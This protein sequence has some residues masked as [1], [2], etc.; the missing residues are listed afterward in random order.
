MEILKE[1]AKAP[2][3]KGKNQDG[4]TISLEDYSGKMVIL[5]FYPKDNTPGCTTEACN[6]RDNYDELVSRGFV[7]I[8]VSPDTEKSHIK[9]RGKHQLPFHLIAD[10]DKDIIKAYGAWGEK[11]LYGR[12]YEGVLRTTY[13]IDEKG[14]ILKIINKVNTSNHAG[15]IMESLGIT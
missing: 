8:G 5:Y 10:P 14:D 3:F 9:F 4:N 7:V 11:S 2:V 15:Q 13:I 12:K 6:L 1:G